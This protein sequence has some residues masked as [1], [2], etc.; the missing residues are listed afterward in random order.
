MSTIANRLQGLE[1]ASARELGGLSLQRMWLRE[2]A[3]RA[4]VCDSQRGC[5]SD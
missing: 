3:W 1:Q 4:L 2:F 5:G